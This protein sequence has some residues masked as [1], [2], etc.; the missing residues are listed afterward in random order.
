MG[1]WVW[2]LVSHPKVEKEWF[3]ELHLKVGKAIHPIRFGVALMTLIIVALVITW[4]VAR[5]S[6]PVTSI[7]AP[8]PSSTT[9]EAK[10]DTSKDTSVTFPE[11]SSKTSG[12]ITHPAKG[13]KSGLTL[14]TQP[15]FS[16]TSPSGSIINQ[17]SS[18][19]APQTVINETPDAIMTWAPYQWPADRPKPNGIMHPDAYAKISV[20][21]DWP[22]AR[23]IVF[24]DRPCEAVTTCSGIGLGVIGTKFQKIA[25]YPNALAFLVYGPNPLP[26]EPDCIIGVQSEDDH[27]V[28]IENVQQIK[29]TKK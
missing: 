9:Q 6:H 28:R 25:G 5:H 27:A 29:P 8:T 7:P 13:N 22:N 15:T 1:L 12:S 24:C 3:K 2:W 26:S 17:G 19:E 21:R 10:K 14:P 23:F 16:V 4:A 18:V 11:K 20:D